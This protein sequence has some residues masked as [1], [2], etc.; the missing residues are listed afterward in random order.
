MDLIQFFHRKKSISPFNIGD[1]VRLKIYDES[2]RLLYNREYSSCAVSELQ[3]RD[4]IKRLANEY[5]G[6]GEH[7]VSKITEG[8]PASGG[9]FVYVDGK[10]QG[11]HG[12]IFELIK[13]YSA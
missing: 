11:Y 2:V 5:L 13:H 4:N 7:I 9:W 3:Y 6:W 1:T 10:E 12:N 8:T